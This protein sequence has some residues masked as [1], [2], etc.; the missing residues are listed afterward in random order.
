MAPDDDRGQREQDRRRRGHG[1]SRREIVV[2]GAAGLL[3]PA[4]GSAEAGAAVGRPRRR[5]ADVVV[6]GAGLAGLTAARDIAARGRSVV[7]LEARDR[8]GGRTLNASVGRGEVV[9]V[10]GEWVG[11]TQDRVMALAGS[12]GIRTFKTYTAGQQIFEYLGQ[13]EL[14]TGLIPPVPPDDLQETATVL[15]EVQQ[16]GLSVP[17]DAP[18]RAPRAAEWDAQTAETWIEANIQTPGARFLTALAI[19]SVF[20]AEPRDLSFLHVLFYTRAGGGLA[21]LASTAGGAQDSRFVGGSQLISIRQAH[22]LGRRVVLRA[23][24]R[25]IEHAGASVR[26]LSDA[27]T[28]QARR[29]IVAVAPALAGRIDY[30]P[31]LPALRDQLTQRV[32]QGSVIKGQAVYDT[33]FWRAQGL[34]GIVNGDIPPVELV[35][36]NSPPTGRPGVLLAFVLGREARAL[37]SQ[38]AAARRAAVV[39]ALTRQ[40]GPQAARPRRYIE[41]NFSEEEWTRGCYAG[42]MPPGVWSDYGAALR[43]PVGRIHW[44]GTETAT[45]WN[46]YMDGAVRSGERAAAEVLARL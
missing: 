35:Y 26:V 11:P 3:A 32:P 45:V 4:A 44:A 16:L 18:W 21:N 23:P 42:F 38:T 40:F 2:A 14:F 33:P 36:D 27:G 5:R 7:V 13:R 39:G 24:V 15:G 34:T 46:G 6:V 43:A 9:E 31:I 41:H 1:L 19:R 17:L 28:F 12:L 20:A 8:V 30:H 10:G 25:R 22:R 29:V 37:A